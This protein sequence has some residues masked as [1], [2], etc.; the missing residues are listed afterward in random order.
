M[1]LALAGRRIDATQDEVI[2]FPTKN[3]AA[4]R[5][6]LRGLFVSFK[7]SVL[8]SSG[9]CGADLLALEVAGEQ[10]IARSM[11]IP[12]APELFKLKSVEDRPGDWTGLFDR[13]YEEVSKEEKVLVMNYPADDCNAFRKTNIDILNRAKALS[14]NSGDEKEV[15]AV[16]V[17]E[18][19]YKGE[20]DITAHFRNAAEQRG[21]KIE[22]IDT[23]KE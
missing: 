22:E 12:F 21:F 3:I 23:L 8:I 19:G 4:V 2:S 20:Q 18:S 6:K 15:R 16:I 1:I 11:V 10:G 5:D 7:P 13:I 14:E 9:S 17:W